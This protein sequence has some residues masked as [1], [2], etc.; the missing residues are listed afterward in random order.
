[1]FF[2]DKETD[3]A[4]TFISNILCFLHFFSRLYIFNY[5]PNVFVKQDVRLLLIYVGFTYVLAKTQNSGGNPPTAFHL[6]FDPP[7]VIRDVTRNIQMACVFNAREKSQMSRITKVRLLQ[8]FVSGWEQLAEARWYNMSLR[9]HH[10]TSGTEH[11]VLLKF[12]WDVAR[13][14]VFGVY[15]CDFLGMDK[16]LNS[17]TESTA[18]IELPNLDLAAFL[19]KMK[20]EHRREII[21]LNRK[22][23]ALENKLISQGGEVDSIKKDLVSIETNVTFSCANLS[24]ANIDGAAA[25]KDLRSLQTD[26]K[27]VL[28]E[29]SAIKENATTAYLGVADLNSSFIRQLDEVSDNVVSLKLET[30]GKFDK[31]TFNDIVGAASEDTVRSIAENVVLLGG[32]IYSVNRNLSSLTETL[33]NDFY[34]V[35]DGMASLGKAITST[36][37]NVSSLHTEV[38]HNLANISYLYRET[39][40]LKHDVTSIKEQFP[41]LQEQVR[42]VDELCGSLNIDMKSVQGE[43]SSLQKSISTNTQ[44]ITE[45]QAVLPTMEENHRS[46]DGKVT[47]LSK[48]M[49]T[50]ESVVDALDNNITSIA[51]QVASVKTDTSSLQEKFNSVSNAVSVIQKDVSSNDR[52]VSSLRSDV[53]S[54]QDSSSSAGQVVDD[55]EQSVITLNGNMSSVMRGVSS[56]S[57]DFLPL[58]EKVT[59][60]QTTLSSIQGRWNS[61]NSRISSLATQTVSARGYVRSLSNRVNGLSTRQTSLE[62]SLASI[63]SSSN[64]RQYRRDRRNRR[65]IWG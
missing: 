7:E 36:E 39:E 23:G 2:I 22:I 30:T 1:M 56:I 51:E 53:A 17:V 21:H 10:R 4:I 9:G 27:S 29:L 64:D 59:S 14:N 34:N 12:R 24:V 47:S 60:F 62:R 8:K 57:K 42:G 45:F 46:L 41:G 33:K 48:E 50:L 49:S 26:V 63:R 43:L 37:F 13:D 31:L 25:D 40:S 20:L 55:L 5:S 19:I 11:R 28:S 6:T 35:I 52:Q 16:M 44:S 38:V 54:L 65:R 61:L 58:K 15:R 32:D 3:S 18:E